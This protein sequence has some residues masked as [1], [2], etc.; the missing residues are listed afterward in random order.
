[1]TEPASSPSPIASPL[2]VGIDLGGT[3]MQVGVVD[4]TR[5]IVGRCKRKTR[6]KRGSDA[7][8]QRLVE[9]VGRACDDA[10]VAVEQ[11]DAIG[12]GVPGAIDLPRGI[13]LEAPNLQWV[14]FPIRDR[15]HEAFGRPVVVDNDVNVAI[16]GES[17]CGVGRGRGDLL[18][19]WIGTGVGGGL[20][21]DDALFHGHRHTAGEIGQ[22]VVDPSGPPHG[23]TLEHHASRTGMVH[24]LRQLLPSRPDSALH[25]ILADGDGDLGSKEIA[26]A[27]HAGDPLTTEVV[28]H[29]AVLLGTTIANFVTTL[30]LGAVVIGGG[31]TEAMGDAL[32]D[33]IRHHY[34]RWVFPKRLREVPLL[35]TELRADAGIHGAAMLAIGPDA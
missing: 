29:A 15:L 11:I 23:R 26:A 31:V 25:R 8:L 35:M 4:A 3:N 24:Q 32:I 33:R 20:V 16:W 9:G 22:I 14:D 12:V 17:R 28:E 1:M 18:G 34:L 7:V 13:V 19:V 21:I 10:G 27:F 30:S 2:T 5:R 6:A